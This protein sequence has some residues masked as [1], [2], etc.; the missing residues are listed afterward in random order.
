MIAAIFNPMW[1]IAALIWLLMLLPPAIMI[2]YYSYL[3]HPVAAAMSRP[4][5][6]IIS[7]ELIRVVFE[8]E[9]D[10]P[11]RR[12]DIIIE[13]KDIKEMDIAS[14]HFIFKTS[15][16]TSLPRFIIVPITSLRNQTDI[17]TIAGLGQR[18]S[19]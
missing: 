10:N 18:Q 8:P 15:G 4:H 13:L 6:V 9:E 2:A 7:P 16:S 19:V 1:L 14:G 12:E 17:S 3:L 5:K 11:R